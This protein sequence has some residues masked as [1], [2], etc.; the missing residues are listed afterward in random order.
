[1]E[2]PARSTGG[3]L[4]LRGAVQEASTHNK[5]VR[6]ANLQVSR[7]KWD[8][9]AKESTRLPN[10]RVLSYLGQQTVAN[11]SPLIPQQ[12]SAFV[13]L[14]A[15]F[16]V[17]QQYR[18]GLEARAIKLQKEIA[19]HR[20]KTRLDDTR[21][22]VKAAY[23]KLALDESTLDDVRDSITNLAELQKTVE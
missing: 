6:E 7:F 23:Y 12:A 8:Y 2:I 22:L 20:L 21:A 17:T 5:E 14:S 18:I 1:D 4:T 10:V 3:T 13:F 15:L 16:P 19:E 9:L 11:Q